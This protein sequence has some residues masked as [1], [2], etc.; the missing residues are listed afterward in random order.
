[1]AELPVGA[2]TVTGKLPD[3]VEARVG[4]LPDVYLDASTL[5][6]GPVAS[7]TQG[8]LV[9]SYGNSPAFV[10]DGRIKHTPAS[11]SNAAA[12]IEATAT[13]PVRRIGAEVEWPEG[14]DGTFALVV[15]SSSWA[16]SFT[17]AGLHLTVT[18]AGVVSSGRVFD[19]TSDPNNVTRVEKLVGKHAIEAVLDPLRSEIA[20]VLDGVEVLRYTDPAAFEILSNRAIWELFQLNGTSGTP[21]F[22]RSAW[23]DK[24]SAIPPAPRG[25]PIERVRKG[26]ART[27]ANASVKNF[28]LSTTFQSVIRESYPAGPAL[29][30]IAV[31]TPPS[32]RML[33][34]FRAWLATNTVTTRILGSIASAANQAVAPAGYTG[35]IS[36]GIVYTGTP[37]A[38]IVISP[39]LWI[40]DGAAAIQYGGAIGVATMSAIPIE[41]ELPVP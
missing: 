3:V 34:T 29:G 6:T 32:G 18:S 31:Y 1:M 25:T 12:Y 35:P 20:V 33:V 23:A 30:S 38:L 4:K 2:D 11:A 5:P 15:P 41:A 21:G 39:Q 10:A 24:H 7:V 17:P 13:G 36:V 22:I 19:G 40:P 16:S 14:S 9:A 37:G 27:W 26:Y 8:S 28:P